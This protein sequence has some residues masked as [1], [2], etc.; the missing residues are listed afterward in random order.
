MRQILSTFFLIFSICQCLFDPRAW[1][2]G[3]GGHFLSVSPHGDKSTHC[4]FTPPPK[5]RSSECHPYRVRMYC[6]MTGQIT[7]GSRPSLLNATPLG[8]CS[9]GESYAYKKTQVFPRFLFYFAKSKV[10]KYRE[11]ALISAK[12]QK[13][14]RII[15]SVHV[16]AVLL[17]SHSG[18]SSP[19]YWSS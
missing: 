2:N 3:G 11:K 12:S 18:L 9:E 19:P 8:L 6:K 5:L 15:W 14:G 4:V 7:Q 1:Q 16:N 13:N 17:H 10:Q